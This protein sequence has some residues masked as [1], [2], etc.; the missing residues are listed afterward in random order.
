MCPRAVA[1]P[2]RMR[3]SDGSVAAPEPL[4]RSLRRTSCHPE[5]SHRRISLGQL[6]LWQ[7]LLHQRQHCGV[8]R[9]DRARSPHRVCAKRAGAAAE[10]STSGPTHAFNTQ[11]GATHAR[12]QSTA[13]PT[14]LLIS[15]H[16]APRGAQNQPSRDVHD[17]PANPTDTGQP[18]RRQDGRS[19]AFCPGRPSD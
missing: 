2:M 14:R 8:G 10:A 6:R 15:A 16:A 12:A 18:P 3:R 17:F 5:R 13:S 4:A 7:P 19:V 1:L 9:Q 11:Q